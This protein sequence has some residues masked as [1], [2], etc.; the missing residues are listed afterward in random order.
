M[1]SPMIQMS[2]T[3]KLQRMRR[4]GAELEVETSSDLEESSSE[5]SSV[6]GV[7]AFVT[8]IASEEESQP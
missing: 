5:E 4:S 6:E 8:K 7:I 2:R 1:R 3:K